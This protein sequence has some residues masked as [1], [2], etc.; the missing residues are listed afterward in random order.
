[1]IEIISTTDKGEMIL[2]G[3]YSIKKVKVV[4]EIVFKIYLDGIRINQSGFLSKSL[5]LIEGYLK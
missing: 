3:G 1:M 4:E 5:E 2:P